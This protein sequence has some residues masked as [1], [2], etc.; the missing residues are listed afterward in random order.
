[1]VTHSSGDPDRAA[2]DALSDVLQDL[3]LSGT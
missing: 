1:M 3:R 2:P